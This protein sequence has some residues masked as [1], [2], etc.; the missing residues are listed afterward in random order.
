MEPL[1]SFGRANVDR[2]CIATAADAFS[3]NQSKLSSPDDFLIRRL[4][5]LRRAE[6]G[7]PTG[8][9]VPSRRLHERRSPTGRVVHR[10]LREHGHEHGEE[11][12]SNTTQRPA[13]AV[14]MPAEPP[15]MLATVRVV[16]HADEAPVVQRVAKARIKA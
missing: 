2:K 7:F 15:V 1:G 8:R 3:A 6:Y 14:A 13:V 5:A 10:L 9:P 16:P 11:A 12:I 4:L